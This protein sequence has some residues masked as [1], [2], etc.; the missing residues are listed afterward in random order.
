MGISGKWCFHCYIGKNKGPLAILCHVVYETL[1]VS[2][3]RPIRI[4]MVFRQVGGLIHEP[5][6]RIWFEF[7]LVFHDI[8]Q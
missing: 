7:G 8:K 3:F 2:L 4:V 6:F 5:Q 1:G